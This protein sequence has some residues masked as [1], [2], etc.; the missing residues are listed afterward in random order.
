M[1]YLRTRLSETT[2]IILSYPYLQ[3][4]NDRLGIELPG[5]PSCSENEHFH[6]SSNNNQGDF[7]SIFAQKESEGGDYSKQ[8]IQGNTVRSNLR[9]FAIIF[10]PKIGRKIRIFSHGRKIQYSS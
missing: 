9:I 2:K 10:Q 4:E 6:S 7:F 3:K 1:V 5:V 8:A